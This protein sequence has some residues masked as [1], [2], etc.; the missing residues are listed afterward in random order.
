MLLQRAGDNEIDF[1]Y[2][3]MWWFYVSYTVFTLWN[4]ILGMIVQPIVPN[5]AI[6]VIT[7][8]LSSG[9][10]NCLNARLQMLVFQ[11]HH[12]RPVSGLCSRYKNSKPSWWVA[13][14]YDEGEQSN[15]KYLYHVSELSVRFTLK[16]TTPAQF[17][18]GKSH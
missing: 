5:T 9:G 15:I 1:N 8:A 17:R 4:E 14:K 6:T 3:I 13:F 18:L 11:D 2:K 10:E 12:A 16:D 7:G